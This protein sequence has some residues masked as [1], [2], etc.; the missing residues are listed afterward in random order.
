[1]PAQL[2]PQRKT[3]SFKKEKLLKID[4]FFAENATQ[5]SKW[6][7]F[8]GL[9]EQNAPGAVKWTLSFSS[10]P[11]VTCGSSSSVFSSRL[12]RIQLGCVMV[13]G[14]SQQLAGNGEA[15]LAGNGEV[16]VSVKGRSCGSGL[17]SPTHRRGRRGGG[18]PHGASLISYLFIFF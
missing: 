8:Q 1:V 11:G 14:C 5:E 17:W 15:F 9:G 4:I 7:L 6:T 12:C 2:N 18:E 13:A 16:A 10:S 3:T